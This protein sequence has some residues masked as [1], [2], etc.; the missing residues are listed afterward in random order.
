MKNLSLLVLIVVGLSA[1]KQN[2]Y[3]STE[4]GTVTTQRLE[5]PPSSDLFVFKFPE[6]PECKEAVPCSLVVKGEVSKGSPELTFPD[7]PAGSTW[8][9]GSNTLKLLVGY[10]FVDVSKD[11]SKQSGTLY[12][13]VKLRS[14]EIAG[15]VSTRVM[16]IV[17]S[18]TPRPIELMTP[19]PGGIHRIIEGQDLN[20]EY[21]FTSGD[22][23]SGPFTVSAVNA[24]Y[25]TTVETIASD[26]TRF[27][28]HFTPPYSFVKNAARDGVEG[29][30]FY[31]DQNDVRITVVTPDGTKREF[32]EKW[33]VTDLKQAPV[34]TLL[35]YFF[36]RSIHPFIGTKELID[37][38]KTREQQHESEEYAQAQGIRMRTTCKPIGLN[39]TSHSLKMGSKW[40]RAS[41][42]SDLL[43]GAGCGDRQAL[44]SLK[45]YSQKFLLMPIK[46][47]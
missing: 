38:N 35:K 42:V 24:P 3:P 21:R 16:P 7:L 26:P 15:T 23:R 19:A 45:K 36:I 43:H 25:G 41:G 9:A 33:R 4:G 37:K 47:G 46:R 5:K 32:I 6:K 14:S 29:N 8:D 13:T 10:D 28:I 17:V 31:K 27:K 18:N 34:F 30:N 22:F 20:R 2:P 1:C 44:D 12:L 40:E 11:P 39:D